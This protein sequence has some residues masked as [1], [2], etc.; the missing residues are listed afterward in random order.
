LANAK[1]LKEFKQMDWILIDFEEIFNK[2]RPYPNHKSVGESYRIQLSE[3]EELG[4]RVGQR[5]DGRDYQNT[6]Q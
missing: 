1:P 6:F 4:V 5:I 2:R 3:G